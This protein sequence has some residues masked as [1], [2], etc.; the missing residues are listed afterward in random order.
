MQQAGRQRESHKIE[1]EIEIS[2]L[3]C[4]ISINELMVMRRASRERQMGRDKSAPQEIKLFRTYFYDA[5]KEELFSVSA[6][7][8]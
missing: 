8:A 6:A 2:T 4:S 1:T 5:F 3:R 7:V